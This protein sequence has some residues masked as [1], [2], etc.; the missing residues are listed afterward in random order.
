MYSYV[1]SLYARSSI[2]FFFSYLSVSLRRE[3]D[4]DQDSFPI[5][6]SVL[7]EIRLERIE[8]AIDLFLTNARW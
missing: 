4:G 6:S 3:T 5:S 8:D 7:E 1:R 2:F